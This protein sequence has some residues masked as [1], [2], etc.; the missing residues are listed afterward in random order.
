M[1]YRDMYNWWNTAAHT[2]AMNAILS[3]KQDWEENE[4][5]HT[6]Q[7][8][9]EQHRQFAF[10]ANVDLTGK[11]ALDFGCGV[12]R[13]TNALA[14]YYPKVVGVDISDE[15]IRRAEMLKQSENVGFIQVVDS[16]LPFP[17]RDMDLVYSTI[18]V[19]HIPSPH[20]LGYVKEFFRVSRGTVMFDAPSHMMDAIESEPSS[21]I[22]LL[23]MRIVLAI[24]R[25]HGFELM[26]LRDFPATQTRHYQYIFRRTAHT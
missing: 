16:P 17:D 23:D 26:A 13:M 19:Q 8:W 15:M 12:G 7:A 9:L 22:F 2:N 6:G 5:F 1:D 3:N 14:A 24:A 18:V 11:S 4:F 10:S 25:R 21:G 20:N